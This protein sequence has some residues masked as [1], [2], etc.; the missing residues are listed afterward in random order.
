MARSA[1]QHQPTPD[2]DDR[3]L[4]ALRRII[5]ANDIRSRQISKQTGLTTAQL[6][7]LRAIARLGE[8]TSRTISLEVSLSPATLTTI[9]DRLSERGFVE[10]YRSD[11]DRRVVYSRLT[12]KGRTTLAAAPVLLHEEFTTRFDGLTLAERESI[13]TTLETVARMMNAEGLDAA[14]LLLDE[15]A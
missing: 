4:V 1:K 14:A 3:V 13:V 8:V 5:R 12:A 6:I 7:V 15:D 10:R 2:L 9:M 11:T